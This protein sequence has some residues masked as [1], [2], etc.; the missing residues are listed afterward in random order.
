M[1]GKS[2]KKSIRYVLKVLRIKWFNWFVICFFFD[3]C[4]IY[5]VDVWIDI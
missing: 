5:V 2:G 4:D 3:Y 1:M